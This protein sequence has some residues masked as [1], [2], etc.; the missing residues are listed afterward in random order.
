MFYL[1][2]ALT[3]LK[4]NRKTYFPYLLTCVLTIM[5][6]YVMNAIGRNT[7]L[8][9]MA[10]AGYLKTI[11]HYATV[12]TGVFAAVFL[13]YTNSF[14]VK[15]RKKE[16]GL[17]QV[18]GMDKRNL[19]KMLACESIV[20]ACVSLAAGLLLG[21]VLGKLMF[22]ILLKMIR[23]AVPLAFA[24]EPGALLRTAVFF[25]AV[26]CVNFFWN[27]LQIQKADP[28]ELLHG[29]NA[30]EKEPKTKWLLTLIGLATMGGGYYIALTTESPLSAIEKFFFAV[31]L[32]IIGTYALFT[33]GSIAMLK[34]LKKKKNFYYQPKH[35]TSIAGMLYR[36]KQNAAGLSNICI[37]STVVLVL[38]SVTVSLYLGMEN[39]M[40]TRFP[41]EMHIVLYDSDEERIS[42]VEQVI[43]EELQKEN[44]KENNALRY[45]CGGLAAV[46]D[47]DL[48]ILDAEE[49]DTGISARVSGSL[50]YSAEQYRTLYLIPLSDYNRME[51]KQTELAEGEV[52]A[53]IP[54]GNFD[55]SK[56]TLQDR[57]YQIKENLKTLKIE[58]R[59]TGYV[60]RSAYVILPDEEAVTE[61]L[62]QY[63]GEGNQ[64]MFYSVYFDLDGDAA[65]CARAVTAIKAHM[66]EI[67]GTAVEYR[68]DFREGFYRMYGGFL[69]LGVFVGA[70]F[71]MA[72]I[73]IIYYKQI[74]EGYEDRSRYQIM[75]QVG[76]DHKEVK[77]SIRSQVLTVFFLPLFVAA[78][79]VTVAFKPISKLLAALHMINVRLEM[80]CTCGTILV[81]AVFYIVV[82]GM[83]SREYYKI[84]K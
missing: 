58:K 35:F 1:K 34:G 63:G 12:V 78:L 62:T 3:N 51:H 56:I 64:Q 46:Q 57:T 23:F 76:M 47:G 32:V 22:L 54:M 15:Q 60:V 29:S 81:F 13:F 11:L 37:M 39:I 48:M 75:M 33:A 59:D 67:D 80:F 16:F 52:L 49:E 50:A 61:L 2:L 82:Y 79:H 73:L 36:M 31:V 83:T 70:L 84:V 77:R 5:M 25:P 53:Y 8:G 44:V 30:G 43:S 40:D 18:M 69:F 26:F 6:F 74:S 28:I 68:D 45:R 71:L 17:Y 20:T 72:A 19:A 55:S 41:S 21:L 4:K 10:G 38:I 27:L 14:L 24:V 66:P 65:A 42:Q 9:E 7:G